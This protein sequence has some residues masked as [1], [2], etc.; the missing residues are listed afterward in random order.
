MWG[1]GRGWCGA[2]GRFLMVMRMGLMLLVGG[3]FF[4][5]LVGCR[6]R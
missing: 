6:M 1:V 2:G 3:V 5:R 4:K